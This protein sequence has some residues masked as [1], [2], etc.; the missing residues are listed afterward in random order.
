M[1]AGLQAFQ[2]ANDVHAMAGGIARDINVVMVRLAE[3]QR[4]L[5][6]TDLKLDPYF[7][8]ADDEGLVKSAMTDLDKLR[9]VYEGLVTSTP[10]YDYRTFA[11][12]IY[13]FGI[14]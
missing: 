14:S 6:A 10:A 9:Q 5:L 4:F 13:G 7:L 11:S 8:S 1:P 3:F 2:T 12:R